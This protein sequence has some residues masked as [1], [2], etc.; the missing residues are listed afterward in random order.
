MN[1]ECNHDG[2]TKIIETFKHFQSET[3]NNQPTSLFSIYFHTIMMLA[4][5]YSIHLLKN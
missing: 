5:K 4:K 3:K 2:N 1:M